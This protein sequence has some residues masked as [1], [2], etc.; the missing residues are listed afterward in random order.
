M[1]TNYDNESKYL[2]KIDENLNTTQLKYY[3]C[4]EKTP[5]KEG[6]FRFC[7]FGTIKDQYDEPSSNSYF[8]DGKC[9]VKVFKKKVAYHKTD[10]NEDFKNSIYARKV[11]KIF[12][13][14]YGNVLSELK[15]VIPFAASMDKYA[16]FNLFFFI[17][18]TNSDAEKKI[19]KH[20]WFAVEPFINGNY[21]KF[22]SN[23]NWENPNL[24]VSIPAFMH[25]NWVYSKG[26]KVVSD[27]QGVKKDEGYILTDPAVQSINSEYGSTDLGPYGILVFLAKHTHNKYCKDLPWPKKDLVELIRSY[28]QS[29]SQRT[30][31]SFEFK[32]SSYI[33]EIY[34]KIKNS[35]I[36]IWM[37]NINI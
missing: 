16:T 3:S 25:W 33:N 11:S 2:Y 36:N 5:E 14:L 32:H 9:V 18:I 23:T 28:H 24:G 19:K 7:Y 22:V 13:K 27:V 26:E 29:T 15:F 8:P 6:A 21:E 34:M 10:L 20:E 4:F 12:N 37:Y 17:P 30:T 35:R 1:G 31:F